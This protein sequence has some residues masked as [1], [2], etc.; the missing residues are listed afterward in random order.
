MSPKVKATLAT[1]G[2]VAA[3][4]GIFL[5]PE[6]VFDVVVLGVFLFLGTVIVI[7]VLRDVWE[8]FYHKFL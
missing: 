3:V 4:G 6:K 5:L 8:I 1:M 2:V 7:F